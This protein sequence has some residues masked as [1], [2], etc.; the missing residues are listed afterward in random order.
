[1]T[2]L[3]DVAA[4]RSSAYLTHRAPM[5]SRLALRPENVGSLACARVVVSDVLTRRSTA[6]EPLD[7]A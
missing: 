7:A 6:I 1:M 4:V 2:G 3:G 5:T